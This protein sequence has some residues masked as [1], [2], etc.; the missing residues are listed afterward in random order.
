MRIVGFSVGCKAY[1]DNITLISLT[2][3]GLKPCCACES[4]AQTNLMKFSAKKSVVLCS[5]GEDWPFQSA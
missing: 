4:F 1:A 2:V 3:N 5:R